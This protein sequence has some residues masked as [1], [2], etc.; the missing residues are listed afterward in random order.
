[1]VQ[2]LFAGN[3][4]KTILDEWLI[5]ARFSDKSIKCRSALTEDTFPAFSNLYA[6]DSL[7]LKTV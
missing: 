1:M 4:Y 7:L 2:I 6:N 5:L 3:I